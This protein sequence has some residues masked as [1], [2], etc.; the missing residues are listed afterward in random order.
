MQARMT[1]SAATANCHH[2]DIAGHKRR[3]GTPGFLYYSH[4]LMPHDN[5]VPTLSRVLK[6]VAKHVIIGTVQTHLLYP[7]QYLIRLLYFG[8][9]DIERVDTFLTP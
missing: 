2:H 3:D 8:H 9:R 7:Y 4:H 5:F 1:D 6:L